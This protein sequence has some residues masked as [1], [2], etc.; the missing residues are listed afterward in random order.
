MGFTIDI[1]VLINII[2]FVAVFVTL[3]KSSS[4]KISELEG[5]EKDLKEKL[6]FYKQSSRIRQNSIDHLSDDLKDV[7]R[8]RDDLKQTLGEYIKTLHTERDKV[9]SLEKD[10]AQAEK[11]TKDEHDEKLGFQEEIR[12]LE[13]EIEACHIEYS[14]LQESHDKIADELL[15]M[16]HKKEELEKDYKGDIL[17]EDLVKGSLVQAIKDIPDK[18]ISKGDILTF[19]QYY[20]DGSHHFNAIGNTIVANVES[21]CFKVIFHNVEGGHILFKPS[22]SNKEVYGVGE[23]D[24]CNR[25]IYNDSVSVPCNGIIERIDEKNCSCHIS[26][27]CSNCVDAEY[28]CPICDGISDEKYG[29][30]KDE[31]TFSRGD[32]LVAIKESPSA[33]N[34]NFNNFN[35]TKG[36]EVIYERKSL[37]KGK[38]VVLYKGAAYNADSDAFEL[39]KRLFKEGDTLVATRDTES[40]YGLKVKKGDQVK[41]TR[42]FNTPIYSAKFARTSFTSKCENDVIEAKCNDILYLFK[43]ED[44]SIV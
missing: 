35:F 38:I 16:T 34:K 20:G 2:I 29:Q 7:V 40:A 32:V 4:K 39:K 15:S 12:E 28:D 13:K 21:S 8:E 44:F 43:A 24:V 33:V 36:D 31:V 3:K 37:V 42:Y 17:T 5:K 6:A 25:P 10:L 18:N 1:S 27:P 23:G 26:P 14:N 9:K 30:V 11:D 22:S 19:L 41:F